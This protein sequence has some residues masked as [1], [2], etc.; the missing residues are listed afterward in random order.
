MRPGDVL[1]ESGDA[2]ESEVIKTADGWA[3]LGK[4]SDVSHSAIVIVQNLL[5][6]ADD[7][8]QLTSVD[9]T[10]VDSNGKL[11]KF[12][13]GF[14]YIGPVRPDQILERL[15]STATYLLGQ[16]YSYKRMFVNFVFRPILDPFGVKLELDEF[17]G[18]FCSALVQSALEGAGMIPQ[19]RDGFLES[20]ATLQQFLQARTDEWKYIEIE[21]DYFDDPLQLGQTAKNMMEGTIDFEVTA[22]TTA[23]TPLL[24]LINAHLSVLDRGWMLRS[25]RA[26]H[27]GRSECITGEVSRRI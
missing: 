8:V 23:A 3:H 12:A 24:S 25:R 14:R 13:C 18:T 11:R 17:E 6:E 27:I 2:W 5:F 22:V 15:N 9:S 16:D 19:T 10:G 20:P 21:P 26:K 1:F 4:R 7:Y